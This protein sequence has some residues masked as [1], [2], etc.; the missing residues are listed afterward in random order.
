MTGRKITLPKGTKIE[1]NQVKVPAPKPRDASQA[2]SW[3][4]GGKKGA[5]R[6]VSAGKAKLLNAIGKK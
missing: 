2:R 5:R 4:K 1:G 6:V 3:A